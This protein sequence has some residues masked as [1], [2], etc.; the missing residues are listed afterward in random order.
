M[1]GILRG[2]RACGRLSKPSEFRRRILRAASVSSDDDIPA[3]IIAL[4]Y[5][6]LFFL[7][8][9]VRFCICTNSSLQ[10]PFYPFSAPVELANRHLQKLCHRALPSTRSSQFSSSVPIER[11]ALL[12]DYANVAA[13][14]RVKAASLRP[15][16]R[17]QQRSQ[18]SSIR[19]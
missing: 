9:C 13:G 7:C 18:N 10:T 16:I 4:F 12:S 8:D 5:F 19:L 11:G 2:K 3:A 1:T 17:R 14:Q 6:E 15:C